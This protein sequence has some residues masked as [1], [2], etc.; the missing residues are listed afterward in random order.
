MSIGIEFRQCLI[1]ADPAAIDVVG[2]RDN[3]L[4]VKELN[5]DGFAKLLERNRRIAIGSINK[6][7]PSFEFRVVRHTSLE[8]D[9]VKLPD[10]RRHARRARVTSFSMSHRLGTAF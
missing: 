10:A 9:R 8:R 4:L 6:I 5:G 2:L 1:L 3:A 7:G